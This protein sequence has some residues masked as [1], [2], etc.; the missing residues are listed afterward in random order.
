MDFEDRQAYSKLVAVHVVYE[1]YL[2]TSDLSYF[3]M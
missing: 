2:L 1:S 3:K